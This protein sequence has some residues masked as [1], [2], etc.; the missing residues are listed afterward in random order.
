MFFLLLSL[1]LIFNGIKVQRIINSDVNIF[2]SKIYLKTLFW[3]VL[4]SSDI[5]IFAHSLTLLCRAIASQKEKRT[6]I[7]PQRS[8]ERGIIRKRAKICQ[9]FRGSNNYFAKKTHSLL[10]HLKLQ[11]ITLMVKLV[12]W[13]NWINLKLSWNFIKPYFKLNNIVSI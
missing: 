3:Q 6:K 7:T 5:W 2:L 4:D 9:I 11:W 10:T 1:F 13:V 12:R 8:K